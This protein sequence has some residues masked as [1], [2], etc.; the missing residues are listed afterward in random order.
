MG[1]D[2]LKLLVD[3]DGAVNKESADVVFEVQGEKFYAHQLVLR[4]LEPAFADLFDF[5]K[6]IPIGDV[7]PEIF[8]TMLMHIYGKDVSVVKWKSKAKSILEGSGKY[9][10]TTLKSEA[11]AWYVKYIMLEVG[12]VVGELLYADGKNCLL[13]KKA[14]MDFIL[15][16]GEEVID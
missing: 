15:E 8:H 5:C 13:L 11:E 6:E 16:H 3:E 4:A 10:L 2:I 14:A 9:G 12:N 1:E 7:Y